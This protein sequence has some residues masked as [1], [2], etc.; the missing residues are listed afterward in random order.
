MLENK[1]RFKHWIIEELWK[2]VVGQKEAKI[3]LAR[4]L[5]NRKNPLYS[6]RWPVHKALYYWPTW[7][8]K[9]E[10]AKSLARILFDDEY[11]YI[12]INCESMQFWHEIAKLFGSPPWYIG[13]D[14]EPI[15]SD[16]NVYA[17]YNAAKNS[18]RLKEWMEALWPSSIIL[19]DEIEKAHPSVSRALMSILDEWMVYLNSW[20]QTDVSGAF[21]LMTSNIGEHDIKNIRKPVWFNNELAS[22]AIQSTRKKA[23]ESF[24]APEFLGRLDWLF[25]FEKIEWDNLYLVLD[26]YIDLLVE[27]V[28]WHWEKKIK[29]HFTDSVR[30]HLVANAWNSI[31][32][33][34]RYF[35]MEIRNKLWNIITTNNLWHYEWVDIKIDYNW[36][37]T[38]E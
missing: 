27:D 31:R 3:A 1:S 14:K 36:K 37:I 19:F 6:N 35:N 32:D 11:W 21:V 30:D 15:L 12:H 13:S 38:F 4:A 9:S 29:L 23:I 10:M 5:E 34:K 16:K 17:S 24:F 20:K 8:W 22:D 2:Y 33:M 7:V 26:K 25:E 18:W 28:D